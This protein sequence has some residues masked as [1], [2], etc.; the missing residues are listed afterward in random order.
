MRDDVKKITVTRPDMTVVGQERLGLSPFG[1]LSQVF[2]EAIVQR[3]QLTAGFYAQVPL[4]LLEDEPEE[5]GTAPAPEI[6]LD[7][8]VQVNAPPQIKTE[9]TTPAKSA[10]TGTEQRILERV[11]ILQRELKQSREITHRL[12]V[13][14]RAGQPLPEHP[15][16]KASGGAA[17]TARRS[18]PQPG[19]MPGQAETPVRTLSA[20][21]GLTLASAATASP[22]AGGWTPQWQQVHPGYPSAQKGQETAADSPAGSILLPDVL[23][24]RRRQALEQHRQGLQSP[25]TAPALEW[26]AQESGE[27]G[28]GQTASGQFARLVEQ[29]VR[30]TL[31]ANRSRT[32]QPSRAA[33]AHTP[34]QAVPDR[35]EESRPRETNRLREEAEKPEARPAAAPREPGSREGYAE[36]TSGIQPEDSRPELGQAVP[37]GR[38]DQI[39]EKAPELVYRT[40]EETE[41]EPGAGMEQPFR[42]AAVRT[43]SQTAPDRGGESRPRETSRLRE[44]R[45]KTEARQTAVPQEPGSREEQAERTSGNQPG[46]SQ[47]ELR[48]AVPGNRED[49]APEAAPELVYRTKEETE[50]EPGIGTES[51]SRA[52]EVRTLSQTAPDRGKESHP[53]ETSQPGK[54]TG[55]QETRQE[56]ASQEPDR[57][58]GQSDRTSGIQ[59]EDSRSELRQAVPSTREGRTPEG[60]AE[61]VYRTEEKT[62]HEQGAGTEHPSRAAAAH[63]PPQAVPD[64]GGE[65]RPREVSQPGEETGRQE[66]RQETASQGRANREIQPE[67]ISGIQPGDSRPEL[68]QAVP[69]TLEGRT[70]ERAPELVYRVE[71]ETEQEPGAGAEHSSRAA[72]ESTPSRTIQD[73]GGKSR[74]REASQPGEETGRQEIRQ[75]AAPQGQANREIQPERNSGTQSGESQPELR[76]AVPSTLE[77]RTP[78]RAPELVYRVEEETEQE[79]GAGAEHSS[80]AAAEHTPSRTAQDRGGEFRPR[81][82]SRLREETGKQE[83]RQAAVPQGQANREIQP[84]RNFGTQSGE[85]QPELRQAVPSAREDRM[86]EETAELVYRTQEEA[87][88]EPG[89][90]TESPSRA[91]AVR[92]HSQAAPDRGGESQ[93]REASHL[94]KETGR[95]QTRQE[96]ASRGQANREIQPE[97]SSGT[98]SGD[99]RPELRQAVPSVQEDRTPE[100]APELVYRTE[101]KTEDEPGIGTEP[102]SRAAAEHTTSRTAPDR[103]R[104]PRQAAASQS[105]DRREE[106]P[107][108]ASG[109]QPGDSRPEL[110]QAVPSVREDR[111]PEETAELVYRTEEGSEKG[112]DHLARAADRQIQF[113]P[114]AEH[115]PEGNTA[116]PARE[117][118]GAGTSV[119]LVHRQD[120]AEQPQGSSGM[121]RA[122]RDIRTGLPRQGTSRPAAAQ[123]LTQRPGLTGRVEPGGTARSTAIPVEENGWGQ[124]PELTLAQP[125]WSREA[126]GAHAAAQPP[127]KA[128]PPAAADGLPQW[129]KELLERPGQPGGPSMKWQAGQSG[130]TAAGPA[131]TGAQGKP[132]G[133]RTVQ[134]TAPGAIPPGTGD[135]TTRPAAVQYRQ[136]PEREEHSPA[137]NQPVMTDAEVRR[138]ADKVYRIIE[139]RLRK[140]LRRSGR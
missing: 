77:G 38:E 36:W 39:A 4:T 104:E 93:T 61:L 7:V 139:E 103:G 40:Q 86:A 70:P 53:R 65:S 112:A 2:N 74:P 14:T 18:A 26:T 117:R 80:R 3:A 95:Q 105:P 41:Y 98:Q 135:V 51:P 67:R 21:Q 58:E 118:Q 43:P 127:K 134:W 44:E 63:I 19:Q 76:Q 37:G 23:R 20:P 69:S 79:P 22:G 62:E 56:A 57:R 114:G 113:Q 138:T 47:P 16:A 5:E 125:A 9:K 121:L 28:R 88:H 96:A 108:Q 110:R 126:D 99:S 119:N 106:K 137:R 72:A 54:E 90:G 124:A 42:A 132:A 92:T 73:R 45:K 32:E 120:R 115:A 35:S 136:R 55:R 140:E 10:Q 83:P 109:I 27:A 89:A 94:R 107:S 68:R 52:A 91:A 33:A 75:A 30:R 1:L 82:T 6:H 129:A 85:S 13:E 87:E 133:G 81:E 71:E 60:T 8:Q 101:E 102:S 46:D 84:E 34:P 97:R 59:S 128:A 31:E 123:L 49:R 100:K 12:V 24:Q 17:G 122:G 50:H 15:G 11:R 78:E 116:L 66:I 25:G 111:M 64:R 48:Q 131:G 29:A 130:Q